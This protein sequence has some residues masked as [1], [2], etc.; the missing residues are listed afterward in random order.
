MSA[1]TREECSAL[2]ASDPLAG[3]RDR[4]VLPSGANGAARPWVYLAGHSL[5]AMPRD[6]PD[7]VA[8]VLR[9][10]WGQL[11]VR[12][13]GEAG[14]IDAPAR[15]ARQLAP[16][17][18]ADPDEVMVCDSTSVNLFKLLAAALRLRPGRTKIVTESATFPTDLYIASGLAD[19]LGGEH[20]LVTAPIEKLGDQLDDTTAVL[21]M[22]H[23]EYQT[24]AL[25]DLHGLTERARAVG[26]LALWD[27]SHS[28][29]VVPIDLHAASVEL[30][31]GCTYKYLCGGPGAPAYLYVRRDLQD[32]V[33]H[34]LEGWLG[35]TDPFAFESDY[36]PAAGVFRL[37]SGTPPMLSMLA[38]ERA[39]AVLDGIGVEAIRAK[40]V[41][42]S[43]LLVS[44]L[45]ASWPD[46]ALGL[47]SPRDP[48][49]RGSQ[50]SLRHP[51]AAAIARAL[52]AQ[53]V[54][55]DSRAPDLVRFGIS[56]LVLRF[57]DVFDAA[58]RLIEIV[59]SRAWDRPEF[60]APARVP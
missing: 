49:L 58:E 17:L 60:R 52:A 57:V 21:L 40:S 20:R 50:I 10:H 3:V 32:S 26:A 4:F 36:R 25:R 54:I 53:G 16:L 29:G 23:V 5:G 45:E 43:E 44:C 51:E 34:P 59:A 1:P 7:T 38:L 24:G 12:A 55:V 22:T 11:G 31:V 18:G 42:L 14:W 56:P 48:E 8:E 19:W 15:L 13:W 46:R 28:A 9:A 37:L 30:A 39:L 6:V 47:A 2:D 27:L 41:A 35:H 33:R